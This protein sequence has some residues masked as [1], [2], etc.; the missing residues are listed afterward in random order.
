MNSPQVQRKRQDRSR[1]SDGYRAEEVAPHSQLHLCSGT[2]SRGSVCHAELMTHDFELRT[3]VVAL[4]VVL[5]AS[6]CSQQGRAPAA[7]RPAPSESPAENPADCPA[8]GLPRVL[9]AGG[10]D[11][12]DA[13]LQSYD[14]CRASGTPVGNLR[15]Y[16]ALAAA[17]GHAV[18]A[19]AAESA[20][21]ISLVDGERLVPLGALGAPFGLEPSVDPEGRV[22]F[23]QYTADS[24]QP[25]VVSV[26]RPDRPAETLTVT[27]GNVPTKPIAFGPPGML[28]VVRNRE[29]TFAP[30]QVPT[31]TIYNTADGTSRGNVEIGLDIVRAIV[32]SADAP[33]IALTG[34]DDKE[35][36]VL[37]D[38]RT[39]EVTGS[40]PA[41]YR[42]LAVAPGTRQLLVSA[43]GG[44]LALLDIDL[45]GR[46]IG[47]QALPS[48]PGEVVDAGWR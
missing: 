31:L 3:S 4:A 24:Q 21:R 46:D 10:P 12:F 41:G 26:W 36:G 43:D 1:G 18:V 20:D 32:W 30:S 6:G 33:Y 40:V 22:G 5:A 37:L 38:A 47:L 8:A 16:S 7:E 23:V 2:P 25:F 11:L 27:T 14:L 48:F 34:Q 44:R 35:P 28:A 9:L 45:D 19:N 13:A 42:A 17:G 29:P 39:L 15:R